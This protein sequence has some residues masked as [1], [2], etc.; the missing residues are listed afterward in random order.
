MLPTHRWTSYVYKYDAWVRAEEVG[1]G[2]WKLFITVSHPLLVKT[3]SGGWG[4][5]KT[6]LRNQIA[7]RLS[8]KHLGRLLDSCGKL[9]GDEE[10]EE[11]SASSGSV[12]ENHPTLVRGGVVRARAVFQTPNHRSWLR[13][14]GLPP[15]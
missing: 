3:P 5:N 7:H 9:M 14:V 6:P 2:Y 1:E 8:V 13:S 11:D 12:C 15:L 10:R 4:S